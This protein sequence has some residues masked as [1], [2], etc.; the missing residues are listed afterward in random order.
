ML[1]NFIKVNPETKRIMNKNVIEN[2]SKLKISLFILP[3]LLL[4]GI[5]LFLCSKNALS[6][7]KYIAIQKDC[8]YFLNLKLSEFPNL[9]F[10]LTQIGDALIFLS[11]VTIFFVYAP[12]IWE[13]LL[14]ALLVSV[15][16]STVLK[17]LFSVGR[18][19]AVLDNNS[20]VI[21]GKA[22]PGY[23][24]LP[25]GHS[26]TIF[27]VLTVL[28]FAFM[29]KNLKDKVLW[30]LSVTIIGIILV[31]TRVAVGAHF[32]LDVTIGGIIGYI[33]GLSGIFISR[34]YNIWAWIN[35][36][37]YLPIFIVLF[38][39]GAI[40]LITKIFNEN[41]V[42]FYFAFA[43]LIVSLFKITTVYVKK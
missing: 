23:S 28:M 26:I 15:V 18:P 21:I 16:F 29:P 41:L 7:E 22:L 11:F 14:S 2:Y 43:S 6:V 3:L 19:A 13:S 25:S 34:K 17:D 5:F 40:I 9:V 8:F 10:N 42:I 24:S 32:P 27:T 30:F 20:F 31:F 37:K 12:K 33:S 1:N 4:F 39:I 38:L 35:N 36:K